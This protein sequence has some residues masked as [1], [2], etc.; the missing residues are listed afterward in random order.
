MSVPTQSELHRP[1]MEAISEANRRMT[2][3]EISDVLTA[4]FKLTKDDLAEMVPSN[5]QTR[6][7]NRVNWAL[8]YLKR[9]GLLGSPAKSHF[10]ILDVGREFL[11]SNPGEIN[12]GQ[13][14][15]IIDDKARSSGNE[16]ERIRSAVEIVDAADS[17]TPNEQMAASY[18]ELHRKLAEDLLESVYE[19]TP[20]RFERLVVHLVESMGY[21]Q[22]DAI[23]GSVDGGV[24]GVINQDA[25]GL[26]KIYIQAKRY[27]AGSVGEPEI[28]NFSGSLDTKGATKGVFITTATFSSTAR[29]SAQT[30]SAGSKFIRLVDG[31]ELT[32]LMIKHG[33]G[34]VTEYTYEIKKL[35]ENYFV[36]DV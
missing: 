2:R 17:I 29:Q 5:G 32:Q 7:D 24:D 26:E 31:K 15:K 8:S 36:E 35:D 22:G 19:L 14:R 34:V 23:G 30:I 20:L 12:A 28:R 13:L 18:E 33:V 16:S 6:F 11:A 27:T 21:G 1:I 4:Q 9:A 10:E 3:K 25:L